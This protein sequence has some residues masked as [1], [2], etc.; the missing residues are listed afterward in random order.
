MIM[1]EVY[2]AEVK[3][4]RGMIDE[5]QQDNDTLRDE[6]EKCD[7]EYMSLIA[8]IDKLNE[9]IDNSEKILYKK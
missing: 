6:L 8:E 2:E 4:L 9:I 7:D 5:L 1:K 3:I